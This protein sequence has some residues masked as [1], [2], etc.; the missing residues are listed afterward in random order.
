MTRTQKEKGRVRGDLERSTFEPVKI[1]IHT[2]T[3]ALRE[4]LSRSRRTG[5]LRARQHSLTHYTRSADRLHAAALAPTVIC[6]WGLGRLW[7]GATLCRELLIDDGEHGQDGQAHQG[8][9][10]L[11]GQHSAQGKRAP[12]IKDTPQ[13]SA[14]RGIDKT[15]R[16][17][18]QKRAEYKGR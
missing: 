3:R 17:N 18:A 12:S 7:P 10:D 2:P 8:S 1:E 11:G 6:T 4:A 5:G 13:A 9:H 16:D 15:S 14:N